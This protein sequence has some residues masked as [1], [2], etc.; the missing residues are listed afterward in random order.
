MKKNEV[1]SEKEFRQSLLA[2]GR[3]FHCEEDIKRILNRYDNLLKKCTNE[4]EAKAI[5][6]MGITEL[7]K[8]LNCKGALVVN[9]QEIL[10]ASPDFDPEKEDI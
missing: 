4:N 6:I 8:F 1:A 10:P 7:H 9:G 3:K 5:K 2:L